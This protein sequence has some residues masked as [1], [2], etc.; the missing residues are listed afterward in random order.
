M[1][2]KNSSAHFSAEEFNQ[3]TMRKILQRFGSAEE[4]YASKDL[5]NIS[6]AKR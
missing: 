4:E 3:Y 1:K 6:S 2:R 5:Q